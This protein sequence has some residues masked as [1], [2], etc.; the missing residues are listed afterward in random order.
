[1]G[2][3]KNWSTSVLIDKTNVFEW[4]LMWQRT[5][6][7]HV[8]PF[9]TTM[10]PSWCTSSYSSHGINIKVIHSHIG[11]FESIWNNMNLHLCY[12]FWYV[13]KGN[14]VVIGKLVYTHAST[15]MASIT[16]MVIDIILSTIK[17]VDIDWY[18]NSSSACYIIP[19]KCIIP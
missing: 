4:M 3:W 10:G 5:Q 13:H 17:Y 18:V 6:I 2:R 14:L 8:M 12:K 19:T 1:M 9:L 7:G 11:W 15:H 16:I